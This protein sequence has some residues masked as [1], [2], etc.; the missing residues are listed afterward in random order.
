MSETPED[1]MKLARD[2]AARWYDDDSSF[3]LAG[4]IRAG[5]HDDWPVVRVT[6]R[7][8]MAERERCAEV[9]DD[10]AT[11]YRGLGCVHRH[12]IVETIAEEIRLG[13][14]SCP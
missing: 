13:D 6:A 14:R 1:V 12:H 7:A 11:F 8:I 2:A 10:Y 9:A 4:E 3:M 5:E